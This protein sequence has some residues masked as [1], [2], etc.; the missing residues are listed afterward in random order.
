L[1]Y[2]QTYIVVKFITISEKKGL[3]FIVLHGTIKL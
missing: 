1:L 3:T 2:S